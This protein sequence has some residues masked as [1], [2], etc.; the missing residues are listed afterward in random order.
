MVVRYQ[1]SA[2]DIEIALREYA[3]KRD[4]SLPLSV[5]IFV[6]QQENDPGEPLITLGEDAFLE[7]Y[8]TA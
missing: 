7:V 8:Q 1:F 3:S 5:G 4:I 2:A 6:M